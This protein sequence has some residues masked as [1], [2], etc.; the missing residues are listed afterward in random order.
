MEYEEYEADEG[1]AENIYVFVAI[2]F[3]L[4]AMA[5]ASALHA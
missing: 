2:L 4:A 3:C 5:L 1:G